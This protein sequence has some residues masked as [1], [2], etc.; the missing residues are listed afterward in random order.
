MVAI[1]VGGGLFGFIGMLLG[2]PVFAVIY[3]LASEFFAYLL[4]KKRLSHS[5][6]DYKNLDI[7]N[8]PPARAAVTSSETEEAKTVPQTEKK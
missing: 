5:T 4:K 3:A 7:N 1:F 6:A 2:V 8:P